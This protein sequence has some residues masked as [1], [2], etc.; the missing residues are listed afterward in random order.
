[1]RLVHP[2]LLFACLA[3]GVPGGVGCQEQV[4]ERPYT[5]ATG[6]STA[7]MQNVY[8]TPAPAQPRKRNFFDKMGD[9]LFG[10]MDDDKPKRS[11][12]PPDRQFEPM[13]MR[14][15]NDFSSR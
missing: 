11:T 6:L 3:L 13:W 2:I 9:A 4:T 10:W 1:M 15:S 5:P 8:G 7:P 12:V 14:T